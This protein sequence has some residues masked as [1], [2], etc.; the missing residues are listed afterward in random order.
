MTRNS[1]RKRYASTAWRR[2]GGC[3]GNTAPPSVRP[4]CLAWASPRG[5]PLIRIGRA[6]IPL[7]RPLDSGRSLLSDLHACVLMCAAMYV[8]VV[9][10]TTTLTFL[11]PLKLDLLNPQVL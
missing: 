1:T 11:V 5:C 9:C 10:R 8:C 4:F 7:G 3:A 2:A 6:A